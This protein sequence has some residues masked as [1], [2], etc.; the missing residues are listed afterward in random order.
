MCVCVWGGG[1]G[2]GR[3]VCAFTH[4]D[5]RRHLSPCYRICCVKV[6]VGMYVTSTHKMKALT[7][8]SF[9]IRY[10]GHVVCCILFVCCI[11]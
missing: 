11:V 4:I 3:H 1:G 8:S 10:F 6:F 2:G 5:A 9:H 7:L